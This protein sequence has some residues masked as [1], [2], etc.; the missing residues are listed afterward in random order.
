MKKTSKALLFILAAALL[1]G[2]VIPGGLSDRRLPGRELAAAAASVRVSGFVCEAVR[3]NRIE[4]ATAT[5]YCENEAGEPVLWDAGASGQE[6]PQTTDGSGAF[7]WDVPAGKWRVEIAKEHYETAYSGR[8]DASSG[9]RNA[10][11]P[12][13]S[14]DAPEVVDVIK[15]RDVYEKKDY[16]TV[17]FSQYMDRD[18][19]DEDTIVFTNHGDPVECYISASDREVS[20]ESDYVYYARSFDCYPEKDVT[21]LTVKNVRNYAGTKIKKTYRAA[22]ET[23]RSAVA[24][25]FGDVDGDGTITPADARLALRASVGLFADGDDTFDFG[26]DSRPFLAADCD[27]SG[28]VEPGDARTILRASVGLELRES[29]SGLADY[30]NLTDKHDVR[31]HRI[32]KITIHH[33]D[34]VMTAQEC[35]DY[36]CETDRGVSVNYCIGYDGSI[37]QNVEEKYRAWSSGSEAND[38]RAVTIEVSNDGW[39]ADRRVSDIALEKL[40]ELCADICL[41]NGIDRLV[42]TGDAYGNLT[43]H[44]MFADTDC[45]GPYLSGKL[46]YIAAEVN[47][48]L[49]AA[50]GES[51]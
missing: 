31:T 24:F 21:E 30:V 29:N 16:F 7:R 8:T 13:V 40:I 11:V 20:G 49:A 23:I 25:T 12:L 18:T 46:G 51:R 5:L 44:K 43:M 19:I 14:A 34:G 37:A 50:P 17:V 48:R 28:A 10:A 36:F 38:M 33:M 6:N 35:C 1:P 42:Y 3:S 45:P 32:D 15:K 26:A 39:D 47:K 22:T 9:L 2:A 41:R 27:S 4:G